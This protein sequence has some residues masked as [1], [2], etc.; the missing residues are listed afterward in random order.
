MQDPRVPLV[1]PSVGL[2]V[3]ASAPITSLMKMERVPK[4]MDWSVLSPKETWNFSFLPHE[5]QKAGVGEVRE[6]YLF[7][8]PRAID[9]TLQ[10]DFNGMIYFRPCCLRVSLFFELII[11]Q[12]YVMSHRCKV[13][14]IE[15]FF[16]Q[17][18]LFSLA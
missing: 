10:T 1:R 2:W 17:A 11:L 16:S 7:E 12:I 8:G 5:V 13:A 9:V 3:S 18:L 6:K 15:A 4:L 14:K